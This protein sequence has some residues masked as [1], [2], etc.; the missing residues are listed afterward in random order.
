MKSREDRR[1]CEFSRGARLKARERKSPQAAL[2][3]TEST[4]EALGV[5]RG[6][7]ERPLQKCVVTHFA[8]RGPREPLKPWG[9]AAVGASGALWNLGDAF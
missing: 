6:G 9:C 4:G 1:K 3:Q 8:A 5:A 7:R 2:W